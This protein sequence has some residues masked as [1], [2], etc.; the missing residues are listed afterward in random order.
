MIIIWQPTKIYLCCHADPLYTVS[1]QKNLF[2]RVWNH[3]IQ[4]LPYLKLIQ[5]GNNCFIEKMVNN[6]EKKILLCIW[7]LTMKFL[8]LH[9]LYLQLLFQEQKALN[10]TI[11]LPSWQR[12]SLPFLSKN[13]ETKQMRSHYLMTNWLIIGVM[14]NDKNQLPQEVT[15]KVTVYCR[16]RNHLG[17]TS[18]ELWKK[19]VP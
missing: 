7:T 4:S 2:P 5:L 10:L 13:L 14:Q 12:T 3:H 11:W 15:L 8:Y 16:V 17:K 9:K 1:I 6:E 19:I 18:D